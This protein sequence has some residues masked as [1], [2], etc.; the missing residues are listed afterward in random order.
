[1]GSRFYGA[2]VDGRLSCCG[3]LYPH[4]S[5]SGCPA[6]GQRLSCWTGP[7]DAVP[8]RPTPT[9]G[10]E[11][12]CDA[13]GTPYPL[14]LQAAFREQR[15]LTAS[16]QVG[17]AGR[18]GGRLAACSSFQAFALSCKSCPYCVGAGLPCTCVAASEL[19]PRRWTSRYQH[20]IPF[21]LALRPLQEVAWQEPGKE[22]GYLLAA[23][24]LTAAA[25]A[26]EQVGPLSRLKS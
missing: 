17:G 5:F 11:A 9:A 24:I 6:V 1:M 10:R 16:P 14:A 4:L 2:W 25:W 13:L 19:D 3:L 15:M 7:N 26:V 22:P 12:L 8:T 23:P 20:G 21:L 18:R